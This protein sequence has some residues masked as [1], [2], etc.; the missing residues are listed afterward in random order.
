MNTNASNSSHLI[1]AVL[2]IL[3]AILIFFVLTNRPL[4]LITSDR[5][6]LIAL[7]VIGFAM[8]AIGGSGRAISTFGMTS[9]VTIIGSA[10]GLLVLLVAGARLAGVNLPVIVDDRAAFVAVAVI[11]VVKV[12]VNLAALGLGRGG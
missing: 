12:A 7:V 6:A 1:P 2:G 5:A 10:L 3:A 8:C 9:P 11:G 4:P